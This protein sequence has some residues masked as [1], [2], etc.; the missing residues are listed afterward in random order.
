MSPAI[1]GAGSAELE[2]AHPACGD[3]IL[4]AA[5]Q[6]W[7]DQI[8]AVW[9]DLDAEATSQAT[10]AAKLSADD[11]LAAARRA[12]PEWL[13]KRTDAPLLLKARLVPS[14]T[15]CAIL[16]VRID[17]AFTAVVELSSALA[18]EAGGGATWGPR[19]IAV[20]ASDEPFPLGAR[21]LSAHLVFR[22]LST[23]AGATVVA[24]D[25]LAPS[26]RLPWLVRYLSSLHDIFVA[27]C[28]GCGHIL[29]PATLDPTTLLP[30]TCR[31]PTL[32]PYH[33]ACFLKVC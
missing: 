27:P 33:A 26:H 6:A 5:G 2:D 4:D 10:D 19:H 23:R 22:D 11:A 21:S 8:R 15:D 16:T 25:A 3:A 32:E 18:R 1:I 12:V 29:R 14:S 9:P 13:A 17:G 28:R 30:A 20:G 7:A 31:S 24:L